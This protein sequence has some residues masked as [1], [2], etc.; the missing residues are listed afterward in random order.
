MRLDYD[1]SHRLFTLRRR[2]A[3]HHSGIVLPAEEVSALTAELK[4]LG[5]IAQRQEHELVRLRASAAVVA[6]AMSREVSTDIVL[7]AARA[8]GSNVSLLVPA[9]PFTDGR[10]GA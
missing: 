10:P 2:L 7:A 8:P 1:L 4:T 9:R 5:V 3:E 6:D